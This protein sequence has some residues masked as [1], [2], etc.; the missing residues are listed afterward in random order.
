M[1]MKLRK[2]FEKIAEKLSKMW[3]KESSNHKN[4]LKIV[5]KAFQVQKKDEKP[6]ENIEN[7]VKIHS[8]CEIN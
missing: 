3:K 1:M 6:P 2:K 4:G 7:R 5:K 8:K